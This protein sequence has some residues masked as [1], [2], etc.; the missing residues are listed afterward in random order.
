MLRRAAA[1]FLLLSI[2]AAAQIIDSPT[3]GECPPD[4]YQNSDHKCVEHPT[5][6]NDHGAATAICNDGDY[7]YSQHHSGTCSRHGG[8][9][10]FL[11]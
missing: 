8:V 3:N 2:P 5:P 7:S 9:K 10:V 1:M 11:R 4:Y 6:Y